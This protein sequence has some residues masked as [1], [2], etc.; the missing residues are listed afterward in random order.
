MALP[1]Q[2]IVHMYR[3]V[4]VMRGAFGLDSLSRIGTLGGRF[5][6]RFQVIAE[7]QKQLA[8]KKLMADRPM[9][10]CAESVC[11]D[12]ASVQLAQTAS[13]APKSE[14]VRF[15]SLGDELVGKLFRPASEKPAPT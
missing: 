13:A 12:T 4:N 8:L 2:Q 11:R 3:W 1:I 6:L 5:G 15:R 10:T 7:Q 9:K 14:S